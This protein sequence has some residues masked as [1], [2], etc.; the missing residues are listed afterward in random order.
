[1]T[2]RVVKAASGIWCGCLLRSENPVSRMGLYAWNI[3]R[4]ELTLF[5]RR[6]RE[7]GD[8]GGRYSDVVRSLFKTSSGLG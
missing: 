6:Y 7:R 3:L 2:Q 5:V 8:V 4:H 1:M